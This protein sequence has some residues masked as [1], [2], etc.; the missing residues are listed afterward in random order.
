MST[1]WWSSWHRRGKGNCSL[2]ALCHLLRPA[3]SQ[4]CAE[5][6]RLGARIWPDGTRLQLRRLRPGPISRG[7]AGGRGQK[8]A[9]F[10][11]KILGK[12]GGESVGLEQTRVPLH[13]KPLLTSHPF[14]QLIL[15]GVQKR[16][17]PREPEV[18][19]RKAQLG[20]LLQDP[21][22]T[23]DPPRVLASTVKWAP[24][25]AHP[26]AALSHSGKSV[27]ICPADVPGP[28]TLHTLYQSSQD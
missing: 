23:G 15:V 3:A 17:L 8:G 1:E 27:K 19:K 18:G 24:P 20:P 25:P 26:G 4:G 11:E 10:P 2:K 14:P 28:P 9:A 21:L 12:A 7:K 13:Q 16:L 5:A 6:G 22:R